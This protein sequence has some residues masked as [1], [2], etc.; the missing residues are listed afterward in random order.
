[1]GNLAALARQI[2]YAGLSAVDP[3]KAVEQRL[4]QVRA[5]FEQG[6]FERLLVIGFG[7]ASVSMAQASE[8]LL[9]DL[10]GS[11]VI[12]TKYGHANGPH[13]IAKTTVYEA[14]HPV[15]DE[16]GA[17]ATRAIV[18]LVG[19]ADERTLVLCLISGGGSAL[20]VA[21]YQGL[22]L[23][24][25]QEMTELLLRSGATIGELNGVRK[26]LSRVKGGRL[27][28]IVY[29]ASIVSLIIS[30]VIGDRL[31][32]IASGPTAPDTS[33]YADA[34]GVLE[35]YELSKRCP[36]AVLS[37][38]ERG[39]RGQIPETPKQDNHIFTGV[40]NIVIASNAMALNDAKEKAEELGFHT[41]VFSSTL[42]GEAREAAHSLAVQALNTNLTRPFC[43]LSGGETT[44]KVKGTGI[45]GRNMELA[46]AFALE[47]EGVAGITLLSAGTDG[48]DGPTDAA[49][50]V[51]D[52]H[53]I[54]RATGMGLDA[55]EYLED[56][57]SYTFFRSTGD[58]LMTGP[59][60][61][62]LMDLQIILAE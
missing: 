29:P 42:Q 36:Q 17:A 9:D 10:M 31:D 21:P 14:A 15:P 20:F 32:V 11:A 51:V 33:T 2:F 26:H 56:N 27:A 5:R 18:D 61:T 8:R 13:A 6:N 39:A 50:A 7:K 25:K 45:G 54:G 43:L 12:I 3:A 35:K 48:T 52:G 4:H 58:L 62:N 34:L 44:V 22:T 59:T 19:Q 38:L 30:D 49:G 16:N 23:G 55:Q 57:N 40:Q 37:I 53:T 41:F 1:M 24:E 60:G 46:L 47:I 28:E